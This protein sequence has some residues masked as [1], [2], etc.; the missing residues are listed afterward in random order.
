MPN[1]Q[2][3]QAITS[4]HQLK[5]VTFSVMTK[6]VTNNMFSVEP[7]AWT[8]SDLLN[9]GIEQPRASALLQDIANQ[10]K[11]YNFN[12]ANITLIPLN[13]QHYPYLLSQIP[14]PPPVL[15]VKGN[16][17][18]LHRT[19]LGVV[20]T[21]KP[22]PYGL[23]VTTSL[24]EP[25]VRSGITI[26]SGLALGIDGQ[27]HRIATKHQAPTVAV[28]GCGVD[29]IYPGDH[30]QLA[31]SIIETGGAIISEFP[32]GAKPERHHFPQRNRII[33]GLSK[34]VLLVEAGEKS[35]ALITAKFAV[36]QNRDVLAVPG[37]IT[38][39]ESIGPLNWL[40]LGATPITSATDI[41]RV[42]DISEDNPQPPP[43][44]YVPQTE[45]ERIILEILAISA[46]H[47]D[48]LTEKSRLDNSVVSATLTLL[49][50]N[51][52]IQHLGGLVY[53][54]A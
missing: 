2:Q 4:I 8:S 52:A 45:N 28:L 18:A 9:I 11:S 53:S 46:L 43:T 10:P 27:A 54:L 12:L 41:L 36:E 40:K 50:I 49:E 25:V 39:P 16:V 26:V 23:S 38:S 22:S 51:G 47:I 7:R 30:R 33:S 32:I 42:F 24:L 13:D 37:N 29:T 21:R 5:S 48:E 3:S 14:S 20:G 44:S 15:Y 6:L 34:A 19:S 35:G 1:E 31:N 17:S